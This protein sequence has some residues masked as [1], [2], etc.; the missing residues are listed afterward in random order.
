SA[1]GYGP[2]ANVFTFSQSSIAV[3]SPIRTMRPEQRGHM[4]FE[5]TRGVFSVLVCSA[6][7]GAIGCGDDRPAGPQTAWEALMGD[8]DVSGIAGP[9]APPPG[10]T[11]PARVCGH[12]SG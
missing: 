8:G 12:C 10:D 1:R 11:L 5:A 3:G 7:A 9:M 6:L 2:P 4:R